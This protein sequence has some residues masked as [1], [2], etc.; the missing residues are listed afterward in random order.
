MDA[1][2]AELEVALSTAIS[3]AI[4]ARADEPLQFVATALQGGVPPAA[5]ATGSPLTS[6][7]YIT[8]H[9]KVI[10]KACSELVSQALQL[11]VD[12]PLQ[13]V[14][15]G[16]LEPGVAEPRGEPIDGCT[17]LAEV[18]LAKATME[19]EKVAAAAAAHLA[20]SDSQLAKAKQKERKVAAR[21][22]EHWHGL[23]GAVIESL[24]DHTALVD[25]AF[26][27][28]LARHGGVLPRRQ[29]LPPAARITSEGV[30]RL[31]CWERGFSLPVLVLSY[32]WNDAFHPDRL[33]ET[34]RELLPVFE[35]MLDEARRWHPLGTVG[36]MVDYSSLPQ[37][38]RTEAEQQQFERGL[39]EMHRWYVHPA[40]HVL[41]V[42]TPL[43]TGASYGNTR[44][45]LARG[46][47]YLEMRMAALVKRRNLLWDLRN[48]AEAVDE[49]GGSEYRTL[50]EGMNAGRLP[51]MS[52]DRVAAEM[53]RSVADGTLAFSHAADEAVVLGMYRR[54]FEEA[55][56]A[57]DKADG[58]IY[59][60]K[61]EWGDA[62]AELL[63][64]A[65]EYMQAHDCIPAAK[66][67]LGQNDFSEQG[68]DK[69]HAAMLRAG[70]AP[71]F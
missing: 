50:K 58:E 71:A 35:A 68:K 54:G 20:K 40:T 45:Y 44:P 32:P 8:V 46:W 16:L 39:G 18:A 21:R 47:C 27:V 14:A 11:Q 52:P 41:V 64:E 30:W 33:G 57:A 51:P 9:G 34:L 67:L 12:Q 15:R 48:L 38:P 1:T 28:S 66:M 13:Y 49:G 53:R 61:L 24:L 69:L 29:E 63:A 6:E 2:V 10:E 60:N 55:F 65:F 25:I 42:A 59:Y 31:Q 62:E 19:Q 26:L 4:A 5:S 22:Q 17:A 56:R 7:E 3:S 37:E 23:G 70:M 43:P 36:V